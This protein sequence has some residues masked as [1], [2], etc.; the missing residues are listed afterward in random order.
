MKA[1]DALDIA[2]ACGLEYA[3]EAYYNIEYHATNTFPYD[4]IN[5]ELLELIEDFEKYGF[6]KREISDSEEVTFIFNENITLTAALEII[7]CYNGWNL[8]FS[9]FSDT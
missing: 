4:E 1:F 8:K 6:V 3:N 7:N 5:K 9:E 2:H